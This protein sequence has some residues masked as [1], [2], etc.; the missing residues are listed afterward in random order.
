M[1]MLKYT[2]DY[3]EY[4]YIYEIELIIEDQTYEIKVYHRGPDY[5][6]VKVY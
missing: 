1:H 2:D 6:H 4:I 5:A 3:L